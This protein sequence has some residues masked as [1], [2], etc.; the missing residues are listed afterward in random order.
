MPKKKNVF[1]TYTPEE[2]FASE[3][4]SYVVIAGGD[5]FEHKGSIVF[6]RKSAIKHYNKIRVD[7]LTIIQSGTKRDRKKARIVLDN[8]RVEPLRVH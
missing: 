2:V 5:V 8:L 6:D 3:A 1:R 7:M 4:I